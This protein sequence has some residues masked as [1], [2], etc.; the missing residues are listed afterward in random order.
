MT[1]IKHLPEVSHILEVD[2]SSR[3]QKILCPISLAKQKLLA[4]V[5]PVLPMSSAQQEAHDLIT[6]AV[7]S[8]F[9][10]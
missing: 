9:S 8:W 6:Q 7:A 4:N 2:F 1:N 3:N 10:S 5:C